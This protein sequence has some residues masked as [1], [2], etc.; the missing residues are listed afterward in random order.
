MD[1]RGFSDQNQ[2]CLYE[3]GR[4]SQASHLAAVVVLADGLTD[5]A[6][7]EHALK[8][9]PGSPPVQWVEAPKRR[10]DAVDGLLDR[11]LVPRR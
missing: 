4:I 10:L 1:L 6:V 5:R 3:L 8:A 9:Q 2:G 7:A 11:L